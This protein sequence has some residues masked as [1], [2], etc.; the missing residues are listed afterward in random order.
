MTVALVQWLGDEKETYPP[1]GKDQLR[2]GFAEGREKDRLPTSP[3]I[4][5][6]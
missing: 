5:K 4:R 2:A 6:G 3:E 1:D